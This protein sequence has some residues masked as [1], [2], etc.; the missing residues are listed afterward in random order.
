MIAK[1]RSEEAAKTRTDWYRGLFIDLAKPGK[2]LIDA[3]DF[4]LN[5]TPCLTTA[6]A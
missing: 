6:V 3:Y 5:E 2:D 4:S 1:H